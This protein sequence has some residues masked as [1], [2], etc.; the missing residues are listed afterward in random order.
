MKKLEEYKGWTIWLLSLI[1][2]KGFDIYVA[3]KNSNIIEAIDYYD[4]IA[5][6]DEAE[7]P[8]DQRVK[9]SEA[10]SA[11]RRQPNSTS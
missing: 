3:A 11:W 8:Q 7:F 1:T 9:L 4:L 10:Y 5:S 6:I 2:D